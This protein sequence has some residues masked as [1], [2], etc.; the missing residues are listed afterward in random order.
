MNISELD[1]RPTDI[2]GH[3]RVFRSGSSLGGV[4]F[5]WTTA[6]AETGRPPSPY[7]PYRPA[8]ASASDQAASVLSDGPRP[9]L[10]VT[11]F[12]NTRTEPKAAQPGSTATGGPGG[13]SGR[14]LKV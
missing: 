13:R 12:G 4:S 3:P 7:N 14:V 11:G 10:T 2:A 5:Q 6:Y 1:D 9:T 8:S